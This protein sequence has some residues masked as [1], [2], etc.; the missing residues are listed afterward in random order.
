MTSYST[1][2]L[3]DIFPSLAASLPPPVLDI[4]FPAQTQQLCPTPTLT[5]S[6]DVTLRW[7]NLCLFC[8][9][10]GVCGTSG[11][12]A[13]N[14]SRPLY[15]K[16]FIFFALMNAS[17]F[18]THCFFPTQSQLWQVTYAVDMVA[19]STSSFFLILAVR[20]ESQ[21]RPLPITPLISN[22]YFLLAFSLQIFEVKELST[23]YWIAEGLYI[24]VTAVAAAVAFCGLV[25]P[26]VLS[27]GGLLSYKACCLSIVLLGAGLFGISPVSDVLLCEV[28]GNPWGNLLSPAFLGCDIAFLGLLMFVKAEIGE[29][30]RATKMK[31]RND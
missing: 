31:K 29:E 8:F 11:Y 5:V 10:G 24:A 19:T 6:P 13:L 27:P 7:P 15:A 28:L 26:T 16:S 3:F 9:L 2:F 1:N 18:L 25:I 12:F 17:A 30:A 14:K 23:G 4:I 22:Y 20:D 21:N